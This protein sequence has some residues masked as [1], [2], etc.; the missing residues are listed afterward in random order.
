[1]DTS[2]LVRRAEEEVAHKTPSAPKA[3]ERARRRLLDEGDIEGLEHLLEVTGQ[4][5]APAHLA[6]AI[7]QNLRFLPEG[8]VTRSSPRREESPGR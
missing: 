5:E 3:L 8:A 7:R 4:A 6:Y 1:V 2:E